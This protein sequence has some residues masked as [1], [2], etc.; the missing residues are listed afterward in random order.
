MFLSL[1]ICAFGGVKHYFLTAEI[2]CKV[3]M[4]ISPGW[5]PCC[6]EIFGSDNLWPITSISLDLAHGSGVN[7]L[8]GRNKKSEEQEGFLLLFLK[9]KVN[10]NQ[11]SNN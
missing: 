8:Q 10:S 2:H 1:D 11:N 5:W 4:G 3:T 6:W 7:F 9:P